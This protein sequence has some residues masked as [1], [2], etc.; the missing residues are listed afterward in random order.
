M[1]MKTGDDTP[2]PR[3]RRP[4]FGRPRSNP[5]NP[6][7]DT[8]DPEVLRRRAFQRAKYARRR[9]LLMAGLLPFRSEIDGHGILTV[10]R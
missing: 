6:R 5:Y 3:K 4:D 8:D 1:T 7:C 9:G 2:R 10:A